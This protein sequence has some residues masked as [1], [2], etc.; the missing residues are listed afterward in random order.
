MKK[1]KLLILVWAAVGCLNVQGQDPVAQKYGNMITPEGLKELLSILASGAME[2]RETGKRGQ[3]MAAAFVK[4]QFEDLGLAG[5]VEGSY[6]Q[7][8]V[9]FTSI[10]GEFYV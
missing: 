10:P 5:P 2:G 8:V 9:L 3:K 6:Y 1:F 7:T 4:A